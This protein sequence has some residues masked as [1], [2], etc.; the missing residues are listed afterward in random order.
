M[1]RRRVLITVEESSGALAAVRALHS[2]GYEPWT[3]FSRQQ[4]TATR[5]RDRAGSIRCPDPGEDPSAYA[6]RLALAAEELEAVA[7]LP[8][9]EDALLALTG[10]AHL[11]P[12]NVAVGVCAPAVVRRAFDKVTVEGLARTAGLPTLPS[13]VVSRAY[14][15]E[16]SQRLEYP[17]ILKPRRTKNV[18]A[19]GSLRREPVRRIETAVSLTR[20]VAT[21]PIETWIVQPFVEGRLAAVCGVAWEGRVICASHQLAARTWPPA[22]G[23]SAYATTVPRD[24][25]REN[26][27]ASLVGL[28][29]WSGIFQAQFLNV[30]ESGYFIDLNPRVYGSLALAVAAGLNLPAIWVRL[31]LGQAAATSSYR[32]GTHYRAEG[33]D[34]RALTQLAKGAEWR[35]A[36]KGLVPRR[37]TVHAT[38]SLRDPL[39]ALA[40]V[41]GIV[42]RTAG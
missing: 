20:A 17:L 2:A 18:D 27:V 26:G 7:V 41:S 29:G 6:E 16:N 15:E 4:R 40:R 32:V 24:V 31:L 37:H 36:L 12:P 38:F 33:K 25:L 14:L 9:S 11:F 28:L 34:F 1:L 22:C 30:D 5:S 13:H 23:I 39:P 3:A 42:L 19:R 21:S 8:G 10:R 35:A